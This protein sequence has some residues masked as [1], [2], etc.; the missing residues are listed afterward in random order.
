MQ[1]LYPSR[2]EVANGAVS[3]KTSA[4]INKKK[5]KTTKNSIIERKEHLIERAMH[6]NEAVGNKKKKVEWRK[7]LVLPGDQ[8][9]RQ[10]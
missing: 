6:F 9:L 10:T 4:K 1:T 3:L 8:K 2:T 7:Y 5:T